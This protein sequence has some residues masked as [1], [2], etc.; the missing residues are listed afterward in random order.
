MREAGRLVPIAGGYLIQVNEA[1]GAGRQRFSIAHEICHTFFNEARKDQA[2]HS[3]ITVGVFDE[4]NSE[5][6]LCDV[7]AAHML[8]HPSWILPIV[9]DE[10]P[11]LDHLFAVR[12]A[13]E[14]SLEATARQL[15]RLDGWEHTA[16]VFW[17]PGFRKSELR[18]LS[19]GSLPGMEEIAPR[20]V[21]KLRVRRVYPGPTAPFIP[22]NKSVDE[23]SPVAAALRQERRTRGS[24]DLGVHRGDS[25]GNYESEYVPFFAR[26]GAL[27]PRVVTIFRWTSGSAAA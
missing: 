1:D 11:E 19:Q 26:E 2:E 21:A 4:G 3:D 20:P 5:E 14:A 10:L 27:R 17:E 16:F 23:D 18:L 6:F 9:G 13:T 8:L 15:V 12:S 25:R 22:L 24:D 7:G